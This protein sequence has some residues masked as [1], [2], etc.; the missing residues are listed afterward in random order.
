MILSSLYDR[1]IL[2]P[3]NKRKFGAFGD[4][5]SLNHAIRIEKPKNIFIGKK[6]SIGKYAWLA[7]NPLTG[8]SDCKLKIGDHT[9]IGNSAHIYCTKSITIE[10]SVLIA[11]RVYIS[12][13]QH[14]F[15]DISRPIID[16]PIVQLA[17]V[18]IK[19]GSWIGENVCI[20]GASV[21]K[22]S[23][24][25]ANS[26]VTKDI[27]DYCIAVGAPAKIIKRYSVE[28]QAW[29]KTDDKGNFIEI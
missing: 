24:I 14:G 10:N 19:E 15:K 2:S 27:P 21:G 20:S 7:A 12:D 4:R 6:V 25:G 29:I 28:K 8:H 22:N 18:I 23:I 1:L 17:D 9:Y 26:V 16:Q 11:D 5:S 3:L 13:N